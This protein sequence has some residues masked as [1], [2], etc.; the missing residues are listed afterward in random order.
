MFDFSILIINSKLRFTTF[1]FIFLKFGCLGVWEGLKIEKVYQF[2]FE[3]TK[4]QAILDGKCDV[5]NSCKRKP[6]IS[7]LALKNCLNK[8]DL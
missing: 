7:A 5:V 1:Y 4:G 2:I 8:K 6:L 3:F